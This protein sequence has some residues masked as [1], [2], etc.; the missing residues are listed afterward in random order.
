MEAR[1]NAQQASPA[2]YT[3]MIGL[4]GPAILRHETS[5]S[6]APGKMRKRSVGPHYRT[7]EPDCETDPL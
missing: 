7:S 5:L 3:A 1:L 6:L 2:A 4:R